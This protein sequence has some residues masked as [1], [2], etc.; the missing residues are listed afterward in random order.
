V[1]EGRGERGEG[2]RRDVDEKPDDG[3]GR[4]DGILGGR[5]WR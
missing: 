4:D 3:G 5:G 2:G 1:D